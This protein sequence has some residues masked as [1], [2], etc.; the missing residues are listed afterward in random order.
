MADIKLY[1]FWEEVSVDATASITTHRLRVQGGWVLRIKD[2]S[3]NQI[4]TCFVG[5]PQHEWSPSDATNPD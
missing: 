5:D 3:V 1:K 4:D 2:T